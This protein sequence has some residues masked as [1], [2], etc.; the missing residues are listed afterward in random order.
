MKEERDEVDWQESGCRGASCAAEEKEHGP[1]SEEFEREDA[2]VDGGGDGKGLLDAE[3]NE[4]DAG[5]DEETNDAT[6]FPSEYNT[7]KVDGHD[8]G[9]ECTTD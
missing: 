1:G 4:E 9:D 3:E 2:P 5:A 6:T 8:T 7:T